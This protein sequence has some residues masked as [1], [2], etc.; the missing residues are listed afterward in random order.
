MTETVLTARGLRFSYGRRAVLEG[1]DLSLSA[2]ETTA[3]LGANGAGKS[4]LLRLLLGLERPSSGEVLLQGRPL[5]GL[6]RAEIARG[7]AYVPQAHHAPFPYTALDVV[8]MGRIARGGWLGREGAADRRAARG[9]LDRVGALPLEARPYTELS[10]GERQ[11][12][13]LAR[14][15]AQEARI[16]VLDEP[17][18]SLDYGNQVRLLS[19]LR[20]L[21]DQGFSV[22]FTTHHPEQALVC[23]D[24]AAIL[25]GGTISVHG[26]PSEAITSGSLRELY[27]VRAQSLDL[28]DGRRLFWPLLDTPRRTVPAAQTDGD[29]P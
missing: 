20:S 27:G 22:L 29:R 6:S 9:A 11:L 7:A 5:R 1:V 28:P 3:L 15:L 8:L 21:S 25:A 4:T 24:R 14:A 13:L 26:T 16:L 18:S 10:G 2:G 19:I 12:V 17:A 23:A